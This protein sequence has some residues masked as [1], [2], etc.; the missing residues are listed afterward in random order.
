MRVSTPTYDYEHSY[1]T[2]QDKE[3]F[4][5][6]PTCFSASICTLYLSYLHLQQI[7]EA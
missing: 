6:L 7:E 1:I 5:C 2:F 4:G 3:G